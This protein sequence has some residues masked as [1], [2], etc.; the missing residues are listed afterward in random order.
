LV[1]DALWAMIQLC[2]AQNAA[3]RPTAVDI[4]SQLASM[5]R[6]TV[7]EEVEKSSEH[8]LR[9]RGRDHD[10]ESLDEP[11]RKRIRTLQHT[12]FERQ[13]T[14]T[15]GDLLPNE[16]TSSSSPTALSGP[17]SHSV[18]PGLPDPPGSG[19]PSCD[20]TLPF[21]DRGVPPPTT[22]ILL[23]RLHSLL[24]ANAIDA[25]HTQMIFDLSHTVFR[26]H[27]RGHAHDCTNRHASRYKGEPCPLSEQPYAT[28]PP[29]TDM[30]LRIP[31]FP[32]VVI[33]VHSGAANVKVYDVLLAIWGRLRGGRHLA[34]LGSP[35]VFFGLRPLGMGR[36]DSTAELSTCWFGQVMLGSDRPYP[37]SGPGHLDLSSGSFLN[38]PVSQNESSTTSALP[39]P[40]LHTIINANAGD[41][42]HTQLIFNLSDI[43]YQPRV[44]GHSHDCTR[45]NSRFKG[46]PCPLGGQI[47]ATD[48][49]CTDMTLSIPLFPG[50]FVD[51]HRAPRYITVFEVLL[52]I[53]HR[54]QGG[55][56][57]A[58]VRSQVMFHGLTPLGAGRGEGT[59]ENSTHWFGQVML[60]K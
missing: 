4:I 13:Q 37:V 3:E 59:Q 46:L 34:A 45:Y 23:P 17:R 2:W 43:T 9:T 10:I 12:S 51:I 30:I 8:L 31:F 29:C 7:T 41:P 35:V 54:L 55:R 40:R 39:I 18:L 5:N 21:F 24:E 50:V 1:T 42:L 32:D 14:S 60:L 52:A 38:F 11:A 16:T 28:E 57:I 19:H 6:A 20:T 33:E 26:P 22:S 58:S 49:P 53:H 25:E 15:F 44:R 47:Y 27:L 48:P 56:H 36:G